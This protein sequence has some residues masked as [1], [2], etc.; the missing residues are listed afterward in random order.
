MAVAVKVCGLTD[1]EAVAAAVGGGARYLGFVFYPPS[2]RALSVERA[3]ALAAAAGD[4]VAKVGVFVAPEDALLDQV[5]ARVALDHLQL[6]GVT[7]ERIAEIRA[8]TGRRMIGVIPVAVA[9][10][11][12]PLP[13]YAAVADLLLFDAKP[14]PAPGWLPGGNALSF[15]WRLLA[16]LEVPCPWLLAGGL[17]EANLGDAVRRSGARA[18]DVSSGVESRPGRK[19]SAK[20][21]RFLALAAGLD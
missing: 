19:D 4:G 16:G 20:L 18:V 15:D 11:L 17:D 5:L 10:D 12:A 1:A 21:R 3:A 7:P 13:G 8:H 14:P 2:P 6:H 9:E